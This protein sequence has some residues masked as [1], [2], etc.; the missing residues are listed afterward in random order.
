MTLTKLR[1][2]N[3]IGKSNR[4]GDGLT[5]LWDV[6]TDQCLG[7]LQGHAEAVFAVCFSPNGQTLASDSHDE[8]I[9]L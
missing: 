9:K 3:N 6:Q 1:E 5:R 8:T 4:K 7:I 2:L